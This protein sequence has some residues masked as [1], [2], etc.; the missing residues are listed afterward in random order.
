MARN[1]E[2]EILALEKQAARLG[3]TVVE[4]SSL[5]SEQDLA[6]QFHWIADHERRVG[7]GGQTHWLGSRAYPFPNFVENLRYGPKVRTMTNTIKVV[8]WGKDQQIGGEKITIQVQ[9]DGKSAMILLKP[10]R[11]PSPAKDLR[12]ELNRLGKVL[13]GTSITWANK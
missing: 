9:Y 11:L 2:E 3:H 10:G 13:Q 1:E 4:F 7:G 6:G 5:A 12:E 8:D